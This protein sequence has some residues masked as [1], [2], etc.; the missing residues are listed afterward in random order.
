MILKKILVYVFV[1]V[2][3]LPK[4]GQELKSFQK[5]AGTSN[6]ELEAPLIGHQDGGK[7][8]Q[9]HILL[10]LYLTYKCKNRNGLTKIFSVIG[11]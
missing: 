10:N 9:T 3:A 1:A 6:E 4:K 5:L 2:T 7:S 11:L 8:G